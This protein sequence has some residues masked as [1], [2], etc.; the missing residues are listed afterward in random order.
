MPKRE[1]NIDASLENIEKVV[2][3][4]SDPTEKLLLA[5]ESI[6][7]ID[8]NIDQDRGDLEQSVSWYNMAINLLNE[9]K[10][11][12]AIFTFEKSI[13]SFQVVKSN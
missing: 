13:V 6:G 1:E 7:Q 8:T 9:G 4:R 10:N 5:V 3:E 12:E 11:E 2:E